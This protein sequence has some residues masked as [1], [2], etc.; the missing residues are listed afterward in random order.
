MRKFIQSLARD[1]SGVTAL[2]YAILA[3]VAV[4]AIVGATATFGDN[5]TSIFTKIGTKL[6]VIDGN[7][8]P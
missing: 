8:A 5:L 3:G 6:G 7:I 2:E 4:A 1:E